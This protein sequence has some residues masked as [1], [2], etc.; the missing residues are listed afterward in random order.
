M[1]VRGFVA[2]RHWHHLDVERRV[3]SSGYRRVRD[4]SAETDIR[5]TWVGGITRSRAPASP[6]WTEQECRVQLGWQR[7]PARLIRPGSLSGGIC[8]WVSLTGGLPTSMLTVWAELGVHPVRTVLFGQL[9]PTKTSLESVVLR[10]IDCRS[11]VPGP[12]VGVT[13]AES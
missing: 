2:T 13:S 3:R 11:T 12:A 7:G 9:A 8:G 6:S 1:P 10:A 5:A 4:A